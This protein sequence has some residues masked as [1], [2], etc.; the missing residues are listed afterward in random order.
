VPHSVAAHPGC[1]G[2]QAPLR[3]VGRLTR[4]VGARVE[5]EGLS[6]PAREGR[7]L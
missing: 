5:A 7:C 3:R 6:S 1:L 4:R 2:L